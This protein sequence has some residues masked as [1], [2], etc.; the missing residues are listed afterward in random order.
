MAIRRVLGT[1]TEFGITVLNQAGFNPIVASSAVVNSYAGDRTRIRW[2][3]DEE[4]PGQDVRGFGAV[5]AP[6]VDIETGMVNTVLTNGARLYVDHAHP[7]Y[8]TPEC[9]DP[10]AAAW[11]RSIA[12]LSRNTSRYR[13]LSTDQAS[14]SRS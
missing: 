3:F 2:S 9:A 12:R 6:S 1:E 10:L 13:A 11:S 5:D 4:S 14:T 7:E 8:S